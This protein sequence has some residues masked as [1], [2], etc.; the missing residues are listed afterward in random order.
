[1]GN[2]RNIMLFILVVLAFIVGVLVHGW[3]FTAQITI[4]SSQNATIYVKQAE[5]SFREVGKGRT[6]YRT[7]VLDTVYVEAREAGAATQKTVDPKR[8]ANTEVSLPL[9]PL[10]K[11]EYVAGGPFIYP[12]ISGSFIYGI[13]PNTNS[14]DVKSLGEESKDLPMLPLLPF[15]KEI[16][17][18][19]SENY[20]YVTAIKGTG[21]VS[22]QPG[23]AASN[24][25]YNGA[26]KVSDSVTAL[27]GSEGLY[28]ANGLDIRNARKIAS[29]DPN[30][31]SFLFADDRYIYYGWLKFGEVHE[32]EHPVFRGSLTEESEEHD[33][34]IEEVSLIVFNHD[35]TKVKQLTLPEREQFY[36]VTSV[37][38][39]TVAV[40]VGGGLR[41]L[42]I[43]TGEI[44]PAQFD[45]GNVKDMLMHNGRLLLLSD[46]GL[47]EYAIKE[48]AFYKR[49]AYP[50]GE[51]YVAN[52]LTEFN[53]SIYF[54]TQMSREE[55]NKTSTT[56]KSS[57]YRIAL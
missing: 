43:D 39:S 49:A 41:L 30:A 53:G 3:L 46:V 26:V 51:E 9:K 11:Y 35:G 37:G 54:S 2:R 56:A 31:P 45:F 29:S 57:V 15:L 12:F 17:W 50:E 55:I 20:I 10:G 44:Q 42:N 8:R 40:L 22:T 33:P 52:S 27:S 5:D 7:K 1:M 28:L 6:V 48:E 34:E 13:N 38:K 4:T 18:F 25:P 19:D 24:L 16:A 32:E 21:V 14:L 23:L 36:R 47:W